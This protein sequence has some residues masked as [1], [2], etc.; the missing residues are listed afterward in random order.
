VLFRSITTAIS[1]G[2]PSATFWKLGQTRPNEIYRFKEISV[3]EAQALRRTLNGVC[4]ADSLEP[5]N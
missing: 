5:V 2:K 3:E 4:T 1:S